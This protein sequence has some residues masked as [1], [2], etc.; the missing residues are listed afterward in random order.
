[1][2]W[3]WS[4]SKRGAMFTVSFFNILW[5]YIFNCRSDNESSNI[6]KLSISSIP[7]I[8]IIMWLAHLYNYPPS[9]PPSI[10]EGITFTCQVQTKRYLPLWKTHISLWNAQK[11]QREPKHWLENMAWKNNVVDRISPRYH[12]KENLKKWLGLYDWIGLTVYMTIIHCK[13][14]NSYMSCPNGKILTSMDPPRGIIT[15]GNCILP[16]MTITMKKNENQNATLLSNIYTKYKVPIV[17]SYS[18]TWH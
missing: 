13:G 2:G 6:S 12:H 7:N 4:L 15:S 17:T 1:M 16:R 8:N 10:L 14:T 5:I 3:N 11:Y 18:N 9:C